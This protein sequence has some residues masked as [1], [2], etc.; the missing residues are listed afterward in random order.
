MP[1]IKQFVASLL[2]CVL[3]LFAVTPLY[4]QNP[5]SNQSFVGGRFV[6]KNYNY[7][8]VR[9][10]GGGGAASTTYSITLSTASVTLPD[11]RV[12]VPFSAGGFNI[13]GQPG[14]FPPIPITV[15]AGT[16]QEVVTPTAVSGCFAGAPQ[17]SCTITAAFTNAHGQGEVVSSG[18]AGIQEAINDAAFFGGGIVVVDASENFYYGGATTITGYITGANVIPTVS[19][20]DT[21]LGVTRYW[22]PTPT[23][24]AVAA[25]TGVP[26]TGQQAC[27]A[28]HQSC[29]DA[30]VAGSA[31]YAGGAVHTCEAYVDIMGNEGPCSADATWTDVST[32]AIDLGLPAASAGAVGFVP[33]IS[34]DAGTYAQAYQI[35]VTS[36]IC[37]LTTLETV[38]PACAVTNA[39]Y[40]QVGST[41]GKNTL[42]NGGAQIP[43]YPL[44]TGLHFTKLAS[45]VQTTASLTPMT[46]SSLTYSY[47]P[48]SRIGAPGISSWNVVQE[49]AAGGISAS[50]T[51]GIPMA[52]GTWTIPANYF[53]YIGAEFRISGKI[54][55]TD[56]GASDAMKIIVGWDS[57]GTNSSPTIPTP[58]CNI[59]NTHTNAAAAQTAWYSCTVKILTTGAAGTASVNGGGFF[60]IATGAAGTLIGGANDTA[61]AASAAINLTVPARI[62]VR[63]SDTGATATGA[64]PLDGV[65]EVLN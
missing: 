36:A 53:N 44:A 59:A 50:S 6:A 56:A 64:Q 60:D 30:S 63:F 46:N 12:I 15:G 48:S 41:F 18:S 39:T 33:Y 35:P 25:P 21:R 24:L 3:A 47:A 49:S 4:A 51:T 17:G 2:A 65:L 8:P 62:V 55:W 52:M 14:P 7:T 32:K 58:L 23:G 42:F 45:T 19:I 61:V 13:K 40:G 27:D 43:T 20:E 11:G 54:T 22:T 38:T 29:S 34:L 28:T 16:V 5:P 9:I 57:A 26:V 10:F 1:I 37:T 31:S